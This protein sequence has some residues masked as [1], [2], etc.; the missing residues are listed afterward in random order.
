MSEYE[1]ILA[2]AAQL[3]VP[4]RLRLINDLAASVPD[5][6]PPQL[7][8]EWLAEIERR[9]EE[10]DSGAVT[11]EPWSDIRQ[12]LWRKHGIADAD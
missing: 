4:D 12:R 11:P 1:S 7:S 3:P 5:D 2:A 6:Q 10:V 9:S 8:Q